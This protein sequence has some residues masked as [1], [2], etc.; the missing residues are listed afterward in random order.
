MELRRVGC[1]RKEGAEV[2]VY[3]RLLKA[4]V[5]RYVNGMSS[6][7]LKIISRER[8]AGGYSSVNPTV[9]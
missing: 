7:P 6:K 3:S 2:C 8:S 9:Y 4:H 5:H 1:S